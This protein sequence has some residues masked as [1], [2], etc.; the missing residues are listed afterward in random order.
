VRL[1]AG[2]AGLTDE[3]TQF[4]VD[5]R[6]FDQPLAGHSFWAAAPAR[7]LAR[8]LGHIVDAVPSVRQFCKLLTT[9]R[10]VCR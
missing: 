2:S 7:P 9:L 10:H 4:N 6:Q 1:V 8:T 5:L 3:F